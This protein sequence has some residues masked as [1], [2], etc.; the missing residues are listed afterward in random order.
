MMGPP[1]LIVLNP[2][3]SYIKVLTYYSPARRII[4]CLWGYCEGR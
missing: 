3:F 1:L 4:L 2:H